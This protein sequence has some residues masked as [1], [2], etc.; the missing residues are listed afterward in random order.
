VGAQALQPSLARGS[1]IG[2]RKG[3]LERLPVAVPSRS[4]QAP[5]AAAYD[6]CRQ[7][8]AT[9]DGAR[10]DRDRESHA[11]IYER[12]VAAFDALVFG[13]YG[14]SDA[15][16]LIVRSTSYAPGLQSSTANPCP[17]A[18]RKKRYL[19]AIGSSFV[20]EPQLLS[21]HQVGE[22]AAVRPREKRRG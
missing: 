17:A 13:L 11:R 3:N 20:S 9:V 1:Y 15:D 19:R 21:R 16:M 2:A 7:A 12:S 5:V 8:A 22:R 14:I 4:E 6:R 18:V 10:S